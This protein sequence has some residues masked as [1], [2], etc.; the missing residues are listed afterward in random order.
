LEC[1]QKSHKGLRGLIEEVREASR[2]IEL[3]DSKMNN[4]LDAASAAFPTL[5]TYHPFGRCC[6]TRDRC[7][8]VGRCRA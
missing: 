8:T 1:N 5:A 4:R 2:S 7:R 6:S 3:S